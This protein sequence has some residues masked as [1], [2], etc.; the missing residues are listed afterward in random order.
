MDDSQTTPAAPAGGSL[1][2]RREDRISPLARRLGRTATDAPPPRARRPSHRRGHGARFFGIALAIAA[3]AG[4]LA[5]AGVALTVIVKKLRAERPAAAP[6]AG[7]TPAEA[8]KA[9]AAAAGLEAVTRLRAH[10]ES[11]AKALDEVDM[12]MQ[13]GFAAK[14]IETLEAQRSRTPDS[15][16]VNFALA[17]LYLRQQQYAQAEPLL[18]RILAA[19]PQ[20]YDARLKLAESLLARGEHAAALDVARW[21]VADAANHREARR[22]MA[23]AALAGNLYREALEPLQ[24]LLEAEPD[25][26]QYRRDLITVHIRLGQYAK[27]IGQL[28]L[29]QRQTPDDP[30]IFNQLAVCYAQLAQPAEAIEALARAVRVGGATQV[31]QWMGAAEFEPLRADPAFEHL[32]RQLIAA[33]APTP[34]APGGREAQL[35][36]PDRA[37]GSGVDE[38]LRTSS[39]MLAP[40]K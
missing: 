19:D 5:Y 35:V 18:L 29:L 14:S 4:V 20:R 24:W 13:R 22:I 1:Y 27:A 21:V 7:P 8:A 32:R 28:G 15:L 17:D 34:A 2:S 39:E 40:K 33:A 16:A 9:P 23:R 25:Q 3:V 26:P 38:R 11:A 37:F 10:Q 12:L 30:Q 31:L 36:S 6:T